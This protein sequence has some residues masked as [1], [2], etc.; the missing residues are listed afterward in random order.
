MVNLIAGKEV[1]PELV[2]QDFTAEKV[3]A[4]VVKILS[5]GPARESMIAGLGGVR[6]ALRGAP[7]RP[8]AAE[9]AVDAIMAILGGTNTERS[10]KAVSAP[11][12]R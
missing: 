4:E 8:P 11:S 12:P 7:D 9:Q 5:D 3:V 2:Q 1:V 6:A 10:G